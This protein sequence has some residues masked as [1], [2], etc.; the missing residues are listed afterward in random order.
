MGAVERK[1]CPLLVV[2]F[3]TGSIAKCSDSVT[4]LTGGTDRVNLHKNSLVD[5]RVAFGTSRRSCIKSWRDAGAHVLP[6]MAL[7]AGQ[8]CVGAMKRKGSFRMLINAKASG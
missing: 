4:S 2:E 6:R 5:V 3:C 1:L 8:A 7:F